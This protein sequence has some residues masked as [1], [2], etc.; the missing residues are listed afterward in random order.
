MDKIKLVQNG[1]YYMYKFM[2]TANGDKQLLDPLTTIIKLAMLN[3]HEINTKLSI[4]NHKIYFQEPN[5]L[6]G[7]S[8]KIYGDKRGDLH[9]IHEPIVKCMEW[10]SKEDARI[11]YIFTLAKTGLENLKISY[12]NS[13]I[14]HSD[15]VIHSIDLYINVIKLYL[16][17]EEIDD[18]ISRE[19]L[20][21]KHLIEKFQNVWADSEI[22]VIY[23]LLKCTEDKKADGKEVY[24]I[25]GTVRTFLDGKDLEVYD[26]IKQMSTSFGTS[27]SRGLSIERS[28]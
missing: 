9:N 25:M 12:L 17:G 19:I 2:T 4:H 8:R 15:L 6:Q 22:N 1:C 16:D 28:L 10:Y 5:L 26:L 13:S 18:S 14:S 11:V 23:H 21:D 7:P 24:D 20:D 27:P 3:F